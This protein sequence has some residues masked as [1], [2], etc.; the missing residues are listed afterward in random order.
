MLH[1]LRPG[2]PLLAVERLHRM[3]EKAVEQRDRILRQREAI[4]AGRR[5]LWARMDRL[6][7]AV[8]AAADTAPEAGRAW[9]HVPPQAVAAADGRNDAES[10]AGGG[11]A[12]CTAGVFDAVP[13]TAGT[14]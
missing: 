12:A 7:D 14:D 4:E 5:A 2:T 3:R 9:M 6:R 13:Q 1:P 10:T 11:S 8:S